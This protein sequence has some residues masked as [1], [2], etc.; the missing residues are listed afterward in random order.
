MVGGDFVKSFVGLGCL[1]V[2][3]GFGLSVNDIKYSAQPVAAALCYANK[4]Y[5]NDR[6]QCEI[7]WYVFDKNHRKLS[8]LK[9]PV[10][11]KV[12]KDGVDEKEFRWYPY[13]IKKNGKFEGGGIVM[14]RDKEIK[15]FDFSN[16]HESNSEIEWYVF[17]K[18]HRKLSNLK[19]PVRIKVI[20]DGVD[21]KE[22]RWYPYLIK[23]MGNLR[24]E[25]L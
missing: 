7:E 3:V 15:N 16:K 1:V 14:I 2:G 24:G 18:N 25:V 9:Y 11:I 10:R 6:G 8:N 19:Y 20:K 4:Q 23:K 17:D 13:L 21:E 22:F 5:Q 12:I